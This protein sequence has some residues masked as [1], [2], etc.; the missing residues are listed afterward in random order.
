MKSTLKRSTHDSSRRALMKGTV[1]GVTSLAAAGGVV[2]A[3]VFLAQQQQQGA[4]HAAAT[5][6]NIVA[7]Q[8][9]LN[10]AA[11]AETL[12]VI[13]YT[14]VLEH[15]DRLGLRPGTRLNIRAALIEEQLH[16][17]FL[18]KQGAKALTQKFSFPFGRR[19]FEDL[20]KFLKVQ[21][22]LESA[23]VA[24][25]LAGVKEFAQAGRPDL[26]QIAGQ[27]G[28][29]EAEHRVIGRVIGAQFPA[30]NEAFAPLLLNAVADAPAFLKGAGYLSPVNG[31]MFSFRA[32][33]TR[34]GAITG[35][36]PGQ[37]MATTTMTTPTVVPA[38]TTTTM[39][40]APGVAPTRVPGAP[41]LKF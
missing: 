38:G 31:N 16:L 17:L 4:A 41:P 20:D 15:A 33:S 39:P 12:A 19:T 27:I 21:Q 6:P 29:I 8:N 18:N 25:Y 37:I 24:A 36:R 5:V 14:Q 32:A 30:N 35:L 10:I 9:I 34:W 28:A 1:V 7:I 40:V 3:G 26:A 22:Q 2:G 11:T 13:F 23:F